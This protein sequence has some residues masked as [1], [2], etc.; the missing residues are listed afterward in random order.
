MNK[1]LLQFKNLEKSTIIIYSLLMVLLLSDTYFAQG[2]T[3]QLQ[4]PPPYQMRIEDMWNLVVVNTDKDRQVYLHGTAIELTTGL[5]V[6]V[7]TSKFILPIGSKKIRAADVGTITINEKNSNYQSVI[8]RLSALP[9]GSYEICVEVID[10]NANT[11]L[12]VSCVTQDVLNLSQVTLMYPEDQAI[13]MNYDNEDDSTINA[14]QNLRGIEK[15]DIWRGMVIATSGSVN[16]NK[17]FAN[18]SM[19]FSWLPPT[20]VPQ[21][22]LISYRIKIVEMY[23]NQSAYDAMQSNPFFFSASGILSTSFVYPVAA[24]EFN[25]DRIYAWQVEAYSE[26]SLLASSEIYTFAFKPN[27]QRQRS[28]NDG[29]RSMLNII[30]AS[31]TTIES[32]PEGLRVSTSSNFLANSLS[33]KSQNYLSGNSLFSIPNLLGSLLGNSETKAVSFAFEGELFGETANRKGSG[34]DR[35]PSYGYVRLTPSVSLYGIPF[36]LNLLLS[37]ENSSGRQ[38]INSASFFYSV[39]AAKSVIENQIEAEGEESVPGLMKFFS[40]FNSFGIGTNYPSYTPFTM[41]GAPVSGLSFEFNPGWFYLA[42]ALQQN[43]KPINNV[44]FR[45]DLYAGRIGVGKKDDSHLF[46]TG[47]Y[48]KDK[49]NS[50]V[51]DSINRILTPNT[52]YVFGIDSRL[53]LFEDKLSFEGE[54]S[55]A[56]LTRDNRDPDLVNED[57]PQFV[58]NIFQPK[59]SSQV[60]YAYSIKSSFNNIE[61]NTKVTAGVR[62]IGPGYKTHGNPTLRN[63]RF[64]VEGKVDQRFLQR[65]IS[66]TASMKYYRD[67]LINSKLFTTTTLAPGIQLGFRFKNYPYLTLGYNPNFLSNDSNDPSKKIDFKNYLFTANTGY[68]FKINSDMN[69]NSNLFYM[70]NKSKSLDSSSGYTLNSFSLSENLSFR[71]PLVIGAGFGMNFMDYVGMSSTITNLDGNVG[72]TFFEKWNNILGVSYSVEKDKSNRVGFYLNSTYDFSENI[73]ADLRIEKNNYSDKL[74]ST[75]DYDEIL[76]RTTIRLKF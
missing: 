41:Q 26:G 69:L 73:S 31:N 46:F 65:Q 58:R 2:V 3:V 76:A 7:S 66:V 25:P 43:Q 24:R 39:D 1:Y 18:S 74:F 55:G 68:N 29:K 28:L 38:N 53:N 51:V 27:N 33:Y 47:I 30:R 71:S 9:N 19:V 48:S 6:D 37:S 62:M 11:V 21:N 72:Y 56:M 63:D 54:I 40:Y 17:R 59:V 12:G 49:S 23:E 16:P 64:E 10:A 22:A 13:L 4:A 45:R 32:L 50:I 70:F 42:T 15:K 35:K 61:S 34:S 8:N 57:I 60:D 75:N 36:G 14:G 44:A 5:I 20:P 67:N 52:N